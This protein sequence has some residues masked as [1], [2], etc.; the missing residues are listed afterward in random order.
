[1]VASINMPGLVTKVMDILLCFQHIC[2]QN[3][4]AALEDSGA[5]L[6]RFGMRMV[7]GCV[8]TSS[9]CLSQLCQR[10]ELQQWLHTVLV[11]QTDPANRTEAAAAIYRICRHYRGQD[12][13][14]STPASAALYSSTLAA[15][16][17]NESGNGSETGTAKSPSKASVSV[18]VCDFFLGVIFADFDL[19][20]VCW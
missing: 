15:G 2:Q 20:C 14:L 16:N 9:A 13:T 12:V 1:M 18:D 8:M 6:M 5:V 4:G 3:A 10:R 17:G 19:V 11:A 7:A